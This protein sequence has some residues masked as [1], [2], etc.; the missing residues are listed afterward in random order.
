MVR[1]EVNRRRGK[2][3]ADMRTQDECE[4][5][6]GRP[7]AGSKL[8]RLRRGD[9]AGR[10]DCPYCLC[11]CKNSEEDTIM[12]KFIKTISTAGSAALILS[13]TAWADPPAT[14]GQW[15]V[16][17]SCNIVFN[18]SGSTCPAGYTC[19][20]PVTGAG[21]SLCLFFVGCGFLY[22]QT[23][24]TPVFVVLLLSF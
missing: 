19:G 3:T 5:K 14:F 8:A 4:C 23:V 13:G 15:S 12:N 20:T 1:L 11:F 21:F 24:V 16:N 10:A 17:A 22:F 2:G 18:Y 6:S 7:G 9:D